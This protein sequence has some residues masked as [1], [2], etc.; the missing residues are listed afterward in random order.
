M[1][2]SKLIPGPS[3]RG[4]L[5]GGAAFGAAALAAPAYVRR[6]FASSG[7]LNWFTWEDYAPQVLVD[8]FQAD[9][10]IKLNIT[11][12]SSNEDALI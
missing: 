11:T 5:K 3:R 2:M 9:T 1:N 10:G 8:R 6:A 4:L 7:E 12:Y